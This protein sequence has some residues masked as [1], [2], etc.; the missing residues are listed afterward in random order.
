MPEIDWCQ[1][2]SE[3][4]EGCKYCGPNPMLPAGK[5]I[6]TDTSQSSGQVRWYKPSTGGVNII[7][8]GKKVIYDPIVDEFG[9]LG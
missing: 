4:T 7:Q 5:M 9:D 3:W 2:H 8:V 1:H 6:W